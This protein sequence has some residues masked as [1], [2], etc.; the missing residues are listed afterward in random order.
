MRG[1]V[2]RD[3]RDLEGWGN[4]E[5][6]ERVEAETGEGGVEGGDCEMGRGGRVSLE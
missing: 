5:A 3:G 2:E 1:G 6:V 4:G